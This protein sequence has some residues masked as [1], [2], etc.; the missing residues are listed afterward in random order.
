MMSS[1]QAETLAIQAVTW[2]VSKSELCD[3]F[4]GASGA[5]RDD[6]R[7]NLQNPEFLVS[8]M[9][10]ILMD[11]AWVIECCDVIGLKYDQLAIVR[12]SLPTGQQIHWT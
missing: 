8:V 6:L 3:T 9:D 5:S 2:L 11:D 4:L 7:A 1:D 10:F 12:A